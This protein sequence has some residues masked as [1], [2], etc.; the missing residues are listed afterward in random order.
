MK[1]A[2][3]QRQVWRSVDIHLLGNRRAGSYHEILVKRPSDLTRFRWLVLCVFVLSTAIN[4]LHR[5]TLPT[6]APLLRRAFN[7]SNADYGLI[8]TAFSVTYSLS[9]PFAGMLI[10]RIGLNR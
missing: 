7:L 9:A 2:Y 5:Q 6:L 8:L 10:D 1:D 3:G 4:Y